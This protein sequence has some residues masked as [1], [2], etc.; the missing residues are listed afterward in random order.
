[1]F[2]PRAISI[3]GWLLLPLLAALPPAGAPQT[4]IEDRAGKAEAKDGADR[5]SKGEP[6]GRR[7]VWNLDGGVFFSTD[8]HAANGSCFRLSGHMTAPGF[9]DG[10]R[11][12]DS[13]EGS[14][15]R[16]RDKVVTEYPTEL[17]VVL[18]LQDFPCSPDLKDTV[19]RPPLT[20]EVMN[21]L[22]LNFYWKEGVQLRP[23]REAKRIAADVRRLESYATGSA[24]EDLAPRYEW[25]Y[26]FMVESAGVPLTNDLVLVIEDEDHKLAARVAARL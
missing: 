4:R 5:E 24:A 16:L 12:V 20:R 19:V 25:S 17:E 2:G 14:S 9:F 7:T 6:K 3:C 1:M 26:A 18:H 23:V 13:D 15:Y 11:R 8:G 21:T 10:L 22:H